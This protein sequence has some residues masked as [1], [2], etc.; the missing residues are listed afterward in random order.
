MY[1]KIKENSNPEFSTTPF[2]KINFIDENFP[3]FVRN[4]SIL[5]QL[6]TAEIYGIN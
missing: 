4:R 6:I 1:C 2:P 5:K 3:E